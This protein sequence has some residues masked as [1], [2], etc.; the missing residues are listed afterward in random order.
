MEECEALCTRM[1][2]MV[3]GKYRCLGSTQHL[4]NKFGAGYTLVA[5]VSYPADGSMPDVAAVQRFTEENFP[6]AVLKDIH[7]NLVQVLIASRVFLAF[8]TKWFCMRLKYQVS[9]WVHFPGKCSRRVS[10]IVRLQSPL[11]GSTEQ[12]A[13]LCDQRLEI[14]EG[15]VKDKAPKLEIEPGTPGPK[16]NTRLSLRPPSPIYSLVIVHLYWIILFF[17]ITSRRVH[18]AGRRFLRNWSRINSSWV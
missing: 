4:K 11:L 9:L 16:P 14:D 7:Q 5:R 18:S 6:G 1:A 17:S 15:V 13:L 10:L 3:N 2:I 12:Q 8:K